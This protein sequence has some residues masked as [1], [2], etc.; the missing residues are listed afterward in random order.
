MYRG[1]DHKTGNLFSEIFPFGGSLDEDNQWIKLSGLIPW[2]K[3]EAVY[4]KYFSEVGRPAKDSRLVTGLLIIKHRRGHSDR[5]TIEQFLENPYLQ[6]FCG[7]EHFVKKGEIHYSTLSRLRKRLGKEY[8]RRFEEELFGV[9]LKERI[10]LPRQVMLDATVCPA[11][12]TYPTDIK[13]LNVVREW[14]CEKIN[15]LRREGGLKEKV[16]TYRRKA[17]KLYL[18]FQK[19]KRKSK[20]II[21]KAKK[22]LL[23]YVCRNLKQFE[24][25]LERTA[26]NIK[27][28]TIEQLKRRL[29]TAKRIYHQQKEMAERKVFRVKDRIVS[30]H[31]PEVRPMVRGKDGKEVEFGPKV[32]LSLVGG[33]TFLDKLSYDAYN[34]SQELKGSLQSYRDRFGKLP[35]EVIADRIFGTRWN[36][37][38]LKRLHIKEAFKPLGRAKL[39]EGKRQ[40]ARKAER[41]RSRMEGVIG[42][43]K[44]KYQLDNIRY[45]ISDGAEIWVRMGLIGMNLTAALKKIG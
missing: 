35:R 12:I 27:V 4:V 42:W 36:R 8:F 6:Y 20:K 33:F 45:R 39:K 38:L 13:L 19:K 32:L 26:E 18:N 10:F 28:K 3:M 31:W 29:E 25:V 43:G 15:Y 9:L 2:D 37:K 17:R 1:K 23:R 21:Q 41:K 5:E 22:G 40:E 24:E 7:Y 44:C 11:N 16:R 30:F 34:E 14:L